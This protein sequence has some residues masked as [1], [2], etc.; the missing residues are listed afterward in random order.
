MRTGPS[1]DVSVMRPCDP[2]TRLA[3][4]GITVHQ[5]S[6]AEFSFREPPSNRKL[7]NADRRVEEQLNRVVARFAMDLDRA[8]VVG[9]TVVIDP[10]IVR[11]PAIGVGY[12]HEFAR[13]RM[14]EAEGRLAVRV[15]HLLNPRQFF[16]QPLHLGD[17]RGIA[18]IGMRDLMVCDR[19]S[20]R[21][22]G[23]EKFAAELLQSPAAQHR[24]ARG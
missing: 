15:Q 21:R 19:E 11:E 17:T 23:V 14:V 20:L 12:R 10:M 6:K 1:S 8:G 22:P 13:T 18:H 7:R 2:F 24:V 4:S 16:E 9:R 3:S 5:T